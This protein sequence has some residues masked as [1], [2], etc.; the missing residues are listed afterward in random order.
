MSNKNLET[1]LVIPPKREGGSD[2]NSD[3]YE[4][5]Y[6]YLTGFSLMTYDYSNVYRPGMYARF[7][8]FAKEKM[9]IYSRP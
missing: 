1:I 3:H 8:L 7:V 4:S 9:K 5:L 2:F 6:D